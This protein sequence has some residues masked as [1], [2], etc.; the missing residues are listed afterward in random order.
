MIRKLLT[1]LFLFLFLYS[2]PL[3]ILPFDIGSRMF[4]TVLGF[5]LYIYHTF[6]RKEF[7]L[8]IHTKLF[9]YLHFFNILLVFMTIVSS[10]YNQT[11]DY[12]MLKL[13]MSFY[14]NLFA[15][16]FIFSLLNYKQSI[17][18]KRIIL[19]LSFVVN[20]YLSLSIL[21]I[22][23]PEFKLFI[24][25]LLDPKDFIVQQLFMF[26]FS[27]KIGGIGANPYIVGYTNAFTIVFIAIYL[28][29]NQCS[30]L[31]RMY[32]LFS[33]LFI[34]IIGNMIART[35]SLGFIIAMIVF[36]L[37][38]F[39]SQKI[40]LNRSTVNWLKMIVIFICLAMIPFFVSDSI[41]LKLNTSFA[42][43]FELVNN[44]L[45]GNGL[46]TESTNELKTMYIF[47]DRPITYLIGD[48]LFYNPLD[49]ISYYHDTDVGYL[50]LIFYLGIPGLILF[51]CIQ[52]LPILLA[53][54]IDKEYNLYLNCSLFLF[55][56]LSLKGMT[57]LFYIFVLLYYSIIYVKN[58]STINTP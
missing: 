5:C 23:S 24:F 31:L 38:F 32:F 48:G 12:S 50:R 16:Y 11:K 25:N 9:S 37:N 36:S 35:T 7:S 41:K 57:D 6:F 30:F 54:N 1:A 44:I 42:Y 47:P 40:N 13:C 45:E 56:L 33:I 22:I 51:M 43:G 46:Q 34:L 29:K 28:I 19:Y 15:A 3:K 27:K 18:L 53:R 10:M 17:S 58:Q 20:I 14:F 49:K 52:F 2:L 21:C 39:S 4:I 26:S 8:H 55:L